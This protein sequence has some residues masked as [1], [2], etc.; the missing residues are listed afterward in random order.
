MKILKIFLWKLVLAKTNSL[1]VI[2]SWL[3]QKYH[4]IITWIPRKCFT[5]LKNQNKKC[6]S[7][8]ETKV[9]V[10]VSKAKQTKSKFHYFPS[11]AYYIKRGLKSHSW[12][13]ISLPSNWFQTFFWIIY[14]SLPSKEPAI[15]V[16]DK[17]TILVKSTY[18]AMNAR[19]EI[20]LHSH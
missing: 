17:T 4:V 12:Y 2:T 11:V 5:S 20:I 7:R 14:L 8:N 9:N 15:F 10:S 3:K 18:Q 6:S 16:A 19:Q 13:S 1:I